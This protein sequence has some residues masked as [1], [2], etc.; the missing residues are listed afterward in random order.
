M[1]SAFERAIAQIAE[2]PETDQERIGRSLL[3]YVAKLCRLRDDIDAGLRSLDA[4]EGS[5]LNIVDFIRQKNSRYPDES[6]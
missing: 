1:T 3:R 2:L 5:E 6:N 4:G